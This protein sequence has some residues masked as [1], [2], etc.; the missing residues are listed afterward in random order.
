MKLQ[1]KTRLQATQYQ[2]TKLADLSAWILDI[3]NGAVKIKKSPYDAGPGGK[4]GLAVGFVDTTKARALAE[5]MIAEGWKGTRRI[6]PS[7]YDPT[8][9]TD[10]ITY[11]PTQS[12]LAYVPTVRIG[13]PVEGKCSVTLEQMTPAAFKSRRDL[14]K[15]N[16]QPRREPQRGDYTAEFSY[17]DLVDEIRKKRGLKPL[18]YDARRKAG[19][20]FLKL[21]NESRQREMSRLKQLK[22]QP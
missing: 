22:G 2:G 12:G 20:R 13:K 5:A 6:Q 15:L 8:Q 9:D 1:S 16:R 11:Y 18:S 3:S 19:E 21:S 10:S 4:A 7:V 14:K 17:T